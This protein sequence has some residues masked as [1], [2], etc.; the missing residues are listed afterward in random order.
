MNELK[1]EILFSIGARNSLPNLTGDRPVV[2]L[3]HAHASRSLIAEIRLMFGSRLKEILYCPVYEG[4]IS[5]IYLKT[6]RL[7]FEVIVYM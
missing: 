7:A 4:Y 1:P 3:L 5:K 6:E 2:I